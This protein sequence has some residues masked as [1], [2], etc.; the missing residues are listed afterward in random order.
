MAG[1]DSLVAH[2]RVCRP[3][4]EVVCRIPGRQRQCNAPHQRLRE[5]GPD[6]VSAADRLHP[7][8]P[9]LLPV[10]R[11]RGQ[12]PLRGEGQVAAPPPA[13]LLAGLGQAHAPHGADGGPGRP[14][15][16]GGGRQ[17]G[18]RPDPGALA[19][20]GA[21]APLQRP[22]EGRQE[23][24]LARRHAQ[25]GVAP[26]GRRARAQAQGRPLLRPLRQ[27]RRHPLHARPAR[28]QLPGAH[29]LG[30]EVHP[31]RAPRAAVPALRHR[32]LLRAVRRRGRPRG[33]RRL[34]ERPH[35]VPLGRHR[36]GAGPARGGDA[37]GQRGAAVRAG[38][39]SAR[40]DR[41]RPQ[42][43]R[44]PADGLG[45]GRG[46]R[47]RGAGRGP[48]GGIGA[49]LP[50]APGSRGG[51]PG[52]RGREGGGPLGARVHGDGR[53]AGLRGRRRRG[54]APAAGARGARRSRA[55]AELA[56]HHPRRPRRHRG[57]PARRQ[58]RPAGDRD[59]VGR[60]GPG[61]APAAAGR[62]PQRAVEGADRAAGGAVAARGAAADRVLRHEPPAGN[63]LRGLHGRAS[64][65]AWPSGRTT[66]ASRSSRSPATTTTPRWKRS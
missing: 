61:P 28:P 38:R 33:V 43:G 1:G 27:R 14:R 31:P 37:R 11:R 45:P 19:D 24:S 35:G 51:A 30:H 25:R 9:G 2:P 3:R 47:R 65:T 20:P 5:S 62:R 58:A 49:D 39:P 44:V 15:R 7:G 48:A 63:R 56:A 53:L 26:A 36:A 18:R 21:P 17:R 13:Q 10:L 12:G 55:P 41:R 29:V 23:L 22:P 54:A 50:R 40:P 66:G 42:G 52:L 6:A 16:V 32:P 60:R 4:C 8:R 64:R 59:A 57:P 46:L 34:R